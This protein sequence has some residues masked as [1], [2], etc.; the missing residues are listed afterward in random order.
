M[1]NT[2]HRIKKYLD[3]K[4]ISVSSFEKK[5]GFSNG[6]FASQLKN[7]KTIGVDKLENIL[8]YFTDLDA[9]WL[10]TGNGSMIK[11]HKKDAL[12]QD[13]IVINDVYSYRLESLTK[14]VGTVSN[15][16]E[17]KQETIELQKEVI[18]NL[19][20]EIQRLKLTHKL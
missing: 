14:E 18:K 7:G 6:S 4:G 13:N 1:E 5:L 12:N 3:F 2:L 20:D 8:K 16:L 11:K 9:N 19:K 17:S 15:L 10:L